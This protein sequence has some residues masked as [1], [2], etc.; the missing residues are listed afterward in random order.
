MNLI[1]S[2]SITSGY[3][4]SDEIPRWDKVLSDQISESKFVS[5]T[6]DGMTHENALKI[7]YDRDFC[8]DILIL[9]FGTRIGWPKISDQLRSK[10]PYRLKNNGYLDLPAHYSVRKGSTQRR[11]LKRIARQSIKILGILFRQYKPELPKDKI[12]NDLDL[13]LTLAAKNFKHV[14]YIQHHHL[15]SWRLGYESKKYDAYYGSLLNAVRSRSE[16]NIYLIEM[17]KDIFS[18]EYFLPDLVHF[19]ALG[20]YK[21]G[22]YLAPLIRPLIKSM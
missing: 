11:F 14:I 18:F 6:K 7:L 9:Y 15:S 5:V 22:L 1:I 10:L 4:I 19:S 21:F 20:H 2:G 3:G 17:P 12:L 13:L 8:G 16:E